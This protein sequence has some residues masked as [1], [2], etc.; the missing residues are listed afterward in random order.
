[1][2]STDDSTKMSQLNS[3]KS[4]RPRISGTGFTLAFDQHIGFHTGMG[5]HEAFRSQVMWAWLWFLIWVPM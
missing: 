5:L 3:P 2:G 1:M 4:D